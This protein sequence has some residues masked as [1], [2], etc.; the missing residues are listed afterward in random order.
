MLT[1]QGEEMRARRQ[2]LLGDVA[3]LDEYA[4]DAEREGDLDLE[5]GEAAKSMTQGARGL[6]LLAEHFGRKG[7]KLI[8]RTARVREDGQ[9]AN[10]RA[11]VRETLRLALEAKLDE[12]WPPLQP[13]QALAGLLSDPRLL[14][15]LGRGVLTEAEIDLLEQPAAEEGAALDLADLPALLFLHLLAHGLPAPLYDHIVVDEAQDAAPLYYAALRRYTRNGSLTI[16]GDLAQ[17]VYS[18]RGVSGWDEVH[19]AFEG[20]PYYFGDMRESYRSTHEIISFANRVLELLTPP[21]QTALLA[22]PF[23]R[24]GPPVALRRLAATAELAPALAEEIAALQKEGY[25]NIAII[26]KTDTQCAQLAADLQS[27]GVAA[28]QLVTGGDAPYE[29]GLVVLPVHLAKG[30]EFEAVLL[31]G[32]DESNY[33]SAEFESRLLY[34]AVTRALHA[35][36]IFSVGSPST[37]LELAGEGVT[38]AAAP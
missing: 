16:L 33:P 34:V 35:L 14:A 30:L 19:A 18:Y 11:A 27:A 6:R 29:G 13:E 26:A 21:G 9:R 37:L 12:M 2:T 36:R 8:L 22:T 17:G 38:S 25:A 5:R 7:E 15:Q 24:H 3:R 31:A 28:M 1:E 23:E 10:A 32:A 4:A 20:M